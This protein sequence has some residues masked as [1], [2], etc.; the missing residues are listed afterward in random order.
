[1][2]ENTAN[3]QTDIFNRSL[4][5]LLGIYLINGHPFSL[6]IAFLLL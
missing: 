6:L 4:F 2:P 3:N 1:M 5:R